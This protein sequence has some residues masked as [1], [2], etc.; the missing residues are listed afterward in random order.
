MFPRSLVAGLVA[1]VLAAPRPARADDADATPDDVSAGRRAAAIAAAIVPGVLVHGAGA[2]VL[3]ERRP[4]KRLLAVEGVGLAALAIG[5]ALVQGSRG[6]PYTIEPG[7]PLAVVGGGLFLQSWFEDI[8]VAAGGPRVAGEARALPPWSIELGTTLQQDAY[9]HRGYGRL[10][11][12]VSFGR[13]TLA[14]TGWLDAENRARIG[15]LEARYT[16]AGAPPRGGDPA[17]AD[18]SRVIARAAVRGKRDDDDR[19]TTAVAEAELIAR[20]ELRHLEPSL[21]G[22]F[23]ELSTGIGV[24]RV[25]YTNGAHDLDS[26]LLG[27]FAWGVFLGGR[28]EA[29][30]FYDHRRDGLAG[31]FAAWRASGFLGS[32]GANAEVAVGGPWAARAELQVGNAWVG[33]L[34]LAYRG[35]QP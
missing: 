17:L 27:R 16:I 12:T 33:T 29:T 31:G 20:L 25:G 7:V 26:L 32:F 10:A 9:R 23:A 5:G 4:A 30:I 1:L 13:T 2:F 22:T 21:R 28:G 24:D 6:N 34:A 19:V 8:W 14:T 3:G 18:S 11:A 35:G 15:E